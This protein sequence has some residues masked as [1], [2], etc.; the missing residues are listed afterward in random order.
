MIGTGL[1]VAARGLARR[2]ALI[3]LAGL[4][5]V[6]GAGFLLSAAWIALAQVHGELFA[7]VGLGCALAGLGLV[8]LLLSRPPQRSAAPAPALDPD[9]MATLDQAARGGNE[10]L[11]RALRAVLTA[12]GLPPPETGTLAAVIAGLVYGITLG[13]G[14]KRR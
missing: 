4:L 13:F 10:D 14:P 12:R 2:L 8:V 3:L 6:I 7:S 1:A 11:E 5:L 9:L